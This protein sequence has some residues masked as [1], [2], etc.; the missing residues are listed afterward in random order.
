V[1]SRLAKD[2]GGVFGT[3]PRTTQF[4]RIVERTIG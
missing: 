2:W 4:D 3:L 1:A